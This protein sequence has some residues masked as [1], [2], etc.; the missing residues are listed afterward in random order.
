MAARARRLA[1]A[2][3]ATVL[4]VSLTSGCDTLQPRVNGTPTPVD[5]S[6]SSAP[7]S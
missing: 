3:A 4:A 6:P 1:A 7:S 5:Q 2:L